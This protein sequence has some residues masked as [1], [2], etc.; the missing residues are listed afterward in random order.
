MWIFSVV[1][2]V[3]K[4]ELQLQWEDEDQPSYSESR[5]PFFIS[6]CKH[7]PPTHTDSRNNTTTQRSEPHTAALLCAAALRLPTHSTSFHSESVSGAERVRGRIGNLLS[8]AVRL[9]AGSIT[10]WR[11]SRLR[12]R[13]IRRLNWRV[14]TFKTFWHETWN[15]PRNAA[16]PGRSRIRIG[17]F[18]GN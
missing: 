17:S 6:Q 3:K 16:F 5:S 15:S 14:L 12:S 1:R 4:S 7:A 18:L 8:A 11:R 10:S 9:A 2:N 13:S